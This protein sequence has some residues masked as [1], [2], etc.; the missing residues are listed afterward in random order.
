MAE[1]KRRPPIAMVV[2][3]G[4]IATQCLDCGRITEEMLLLTLSSVV[5]F[6]LRCEEYIRTPLW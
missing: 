5:T 1:G 3:F 4:Y 2:Q 6:P